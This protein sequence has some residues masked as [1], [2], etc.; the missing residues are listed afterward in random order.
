MRA[1]AASLLPPPKPA[2]AGIRL[3]ICRSTPLFNRSANDSRAWYA[4]LD[5]PSG[6]APGG[7]HLTVIPPGAAVR[8]RVSARL[9]VCITEM[10]S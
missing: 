4:R 3:M 5:R 9:I 10:I 1:A 8:T 6:A 7:V 2:A